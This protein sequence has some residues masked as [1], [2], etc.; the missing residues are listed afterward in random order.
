MPK[1]LSK[2]EKKYLDRIQQQGCCV[3]RYIL[4]YYDTPAEIH[5]IRNGQGGSQRAST[6]ETLPLC[7]P[8]HRTGG[9]GIA[10]HAGQETWEQKYGTEREFLDKVHSEYEETYNEPVPN[11]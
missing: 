10:L 4:G 9:H 11:F 8:H 1:Q 5:H 2:A 3:C 7:P 6:D